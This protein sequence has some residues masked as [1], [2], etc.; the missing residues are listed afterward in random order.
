MLVRYFS[1]VIIFVLHYIC[2]CSSVYG[3]VY[4]AVTF[5]ERVHRF[6]AK[7][8]VERCEQVQ[9]YT[10]IVNFNWRRNVEM[11]CCTNR[12]QIKSFSCNKKREKKYWIECVGQ[13]RL[14]TMLQYQ[15]QWTGNIVSMDV[16]GTRHSRCTHY[17][18][19]NVVMKIFVSSTSGVLAFLNKCVV[20]N[21]CVGCTAERNQPITITI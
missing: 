11:D 1:V 5:Q 2:L 10:C 4:N 8:D 6:Q 13:E 18:N 21:N 7:H 16:R 20:R 15:Q 3:D 14:F 17:I 9:N 19:H 12:W